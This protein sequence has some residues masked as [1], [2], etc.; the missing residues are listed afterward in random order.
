MLTGTAI[1]A[2]RESE[3]ILGSQRAIDL[4][5]PFIPANCEIRVV[6]DYRTLGPL[7][8]RSVL[9]S[10][11]DPMLAGLGKVSGAEVIPGISSLQVACARL[12]VPIERV[13]TVIAH[14]RDHG[15]ALEA[16][17]AEVRLGKTVFLIADPRF[18]IRALADALCTDRF[19][20]TITLC[21]DLG[22]P[23]EKILHGT[24]EDPPIPSS[25]LFVILIGSFSRD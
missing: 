5:A 25:R 8:D 4:A 14:G 12:Q 3:L 11:G 21:E 2:I 24:P 23:A 10:T 18:D 17:C 13:T 9:L 7:K 6:R 1:A 16:T 15:A 20:G 19:K 22:Y